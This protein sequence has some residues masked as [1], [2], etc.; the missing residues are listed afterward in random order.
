MFKLGLLIY[1]GV[2]P[3]IL[4]EPNESHMP[5]QKIKILGKCLVIMF[6]GG[7]M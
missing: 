4:P 7:K 6:R 2:S 3:S 1:E 5:T